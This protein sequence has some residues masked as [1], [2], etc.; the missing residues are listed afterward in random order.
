MSANSKFHIP[1]CSQGSVVFG[2]AT[3]LVQSRRE[4][5]DIQDGVQD[6]RQNKLCQ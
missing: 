5:L 1:K 4:S 2:M 3:H 6:G